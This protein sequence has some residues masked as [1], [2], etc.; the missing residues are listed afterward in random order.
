MD[1]T[2]YGI[3][4]PNEIVRLGLHLGMNGPDGGYPAGDQMQ[5]KVTPEPTTMLLV[6]AVAAGLGVVRKKRLLV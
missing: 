5:V 2:T 3:D 1:F 4:R 6:G